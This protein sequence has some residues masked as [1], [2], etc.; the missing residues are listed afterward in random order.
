[1]DGKVVEGVWKALIY[2]GKDNG[3]TTARLSAMKDKSP[4]DYFVAIRVSPHDGGIYLALKE[5]K[6]ATPIQHGDWEK[7]VGERAAWRDLLD[8]GRRIVGLD[9]LNDCQRNGRAAF[10]P[11]NVCPSRL[12]FG[13]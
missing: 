5:R 10:W 3:K 11:E 9:E 12:P 4:D 8:D 6:D 13:R 7:F 1:M 2:G